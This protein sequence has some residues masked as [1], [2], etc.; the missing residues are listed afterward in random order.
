MVREGPDAINLRGEAAVVVDGDT[1]SIALSGH[2]ADQLAAGDNTAEDRP[3]GEGDI[4][5]DPV[6][7][8]RLPGAEEFEGLVELLL[9]TAGDS[10]CLFSYQ[11]P[12]KG[13]QFGYFRKLKIR[14]VA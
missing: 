9:A 14:L 11:A 1:K 3:R 4:V 6:D 10:I 7:P 8:S 5:E 2:T 12:M 13:N